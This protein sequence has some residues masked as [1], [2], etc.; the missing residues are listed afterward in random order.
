MLL[1]ESFIDLQADDLGLRTSLG[2]LP[3]KNVVE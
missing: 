2:P 3:G 1:L